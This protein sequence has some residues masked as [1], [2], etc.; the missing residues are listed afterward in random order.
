MHLW[1]TAVWVSSSTDPGWALSLLGESASWRL[2]YEEVGWDCW[3]PIHMVSPLN[4]R[5]AW[6]C[7][8]GF[9]ETA[10]TSKTSWGLSLNRHIVTFTSFHWPKQVIRPVQTRKGKET[11]PTSS[12]E[13]LESP[14]ARSM[15][16][17]RN[18]NWEHFYNQS[19]AYVPWWA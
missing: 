15:G 16:V 9:W 1:T 11:G 10:E 17:G 12:C 4:R 2:V 8:Q 3:A 19:A 5:P 7:S 14:T 6:A 13:K 18:E